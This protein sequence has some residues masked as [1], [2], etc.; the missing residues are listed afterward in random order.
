MS[1]NEFR[2][3]GDPATLAL[4]VRLLDD[5]DGNAHAPMSSVGSWAQWRLW[6]NGVNVTR[7]QIV[8]ASGEALT[9]EGVRWYVA[10]LLRWLVE[11]WLPLLHETRLPSGAWRAGG[12]T[13]RSARGLYLSMIEAAGDDPQRFADWQTWAERH[14]LR[15]AAEGGILPDLFFQRIGD[16][17]EISWGDRVDPGTEATAF[18]IED[19][20][21][22][23]SISAF[24]LAFSG[25]ID[26]LLADPMI[27]EQEWAAEICRRWTSIA[28]EVERSALPWYLD[29][30]ELSGPLATRVLTVFE[31][32]GVP[33]ASNDNGRWMGELSPPVA[34][35]GDVS[36]RM[37][38][39]GVALL[40]G[41]YIAA[42]GAYDETDADRLSEDDPAWAASSPW[43]SGYGLALDIL[44]EA[45]PSP[46]SSKTQLERLLVDLGIRLR[47]VALSSDGPRGVALAG[48]G[49]A[50]TIIV[51]EDHISN[52]GQGRR[53]TIAHELCHILFDRGRARTLAHSSTPWAPV[54]IE[55]RANAFAAMLLMPPYRCRLDHDG[56]LVRLRQ[57]VERLASA[58]AVSCSALRHHLA[59][60]GEI[61]SYEYAQLSREGTRGLN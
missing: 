57:Q 1:W 3:F 32:E 48:V 14:A 42:Q 46:R 40:L 2:Q 44:D 9:E 15:T 56:D 11:H 18:L 31:R 21:S 12:S 36:P 58:L 50:P 24:G 28:A 53:F 54:S 39:Q 19:G 30:Q 5:P 51:N 10:P 22:R 7:V 20:V 34:M 43:D 33:L 29:A 6:L 41:E 35:F 17:M 38:E 37:S 16:D 61:S 8:A 13:K 23:V 59:N 47:M 27:A 60:I 55:Q 49:L 52:E 25:A 45:D 4:D 26:A